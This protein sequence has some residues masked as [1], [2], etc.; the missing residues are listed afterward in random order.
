M[1]IVCGQITM[2]N[3]V[4]LKRLDHKKHHKLSKKP[5]TTSLTL[6]VK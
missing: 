5:K 2:S 3:K 1:L 4:I 6:R